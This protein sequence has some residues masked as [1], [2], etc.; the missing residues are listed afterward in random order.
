MLWL[1]WQ[2]SNLQPT[3]PEPVALPIAPHP[4]VVD[5]VGI[6]PTMTT[7]SEWCLTAW[8]RVGYGAGDGI[9][10][11]DSHVGNVVLYQ[12]SYT[13]MFIRPS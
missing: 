4:S 3:G 12:L 9:R 5:P 8:L 7:L 13:C 10:T 2:G 11:H 6:A 1:G